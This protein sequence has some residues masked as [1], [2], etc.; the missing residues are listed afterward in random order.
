[1]TDAQDKQDTRP[2]D[3]QRAAVRTGAGPAGGDAGGPGDKALDTGSEWARARDS[4]KTK[5]IASVV[6]FWVSAS[7]WG[8]V[9]FID[10]KVNLILTSIVLG[11]LV[12]GM[13][14][15]TRYQLHLRNEPTEASARGQDN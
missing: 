2:H 14:L 5:W 8:V 7:V 11:M 3:T 10:G 4:L 15:K 1:M 13:W 12:I 6:A 9:L